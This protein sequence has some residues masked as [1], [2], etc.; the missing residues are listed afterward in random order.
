MRK[1]SILAFNGLLICNWISDLRNTFRF[2]K[3]WFFIGSPPWKKLD[4]YH[5]SKQKLR[6]S[7]WKNSGSEFY[8]QGGNL[9]KS[10]VPSSKSLFR[11]QIKRLN[12]YFCAGVKHSWKNCWCHLW[13]APFWNP[14]LDAKMCTRVYYSR[15]DSI[16][17]IRKQGRRSVGKFRLCSFFSWKKFDWNCTQQ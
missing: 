2:C 4:L 7:P 6:W 11:V 9:E 17:V 13:T 5:K 16:L 10:Q 8:F 12:L 15:R 14:L 1:L 3:P